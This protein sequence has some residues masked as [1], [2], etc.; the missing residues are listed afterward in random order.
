M[1]DPSKLVDWLKLPTKAFVGLAL[2]SGILIFSSAQL[3]THLGLVNFVSTYR[4]YLGAVFIFGISFTLVYCLSSVFTVI[5]PWVTQTYNIHKYKK[6]MYDLTPEEKKILSSYISRQT[7]SQPLD[8]RSGVVSSL[9]SAGI[10]YRATSVGT[11]T[12]FEF[13]IH[14]WARKFLKKYP[15]VLE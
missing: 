4:P 14:P 8:I 11:F 6:R 5:Q 7:L 1:F 9:V 15:H 2:A 13:V 3:L 12:E 10:I